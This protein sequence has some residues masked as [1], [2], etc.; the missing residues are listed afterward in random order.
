MPPAQRQI[1]QQRDV[2]IANARY[3]WARLALGSGQTELA[4]KAFR[5]ALELRRKA[6]GKDHPDVAKVV[7]T[8]AGICQ[9]QGRFIE[10]EQLCREGVE[11]RRRILPPGTWT[12]GNAKS[13]LGENLM[14]QRKF[15]E[16]ERLL[17]EANEDFDAHPPPATEAKMVGF[18]LQRLVW[19]YEQ[20]GKP[21]QAAAW[22]AK[23]PPGAEPLNTRIF[24][25]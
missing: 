15:S 14:G 12:T 6:F 5:E 23:V 10:A 9:K 7:L 22:R 20:W 19:L 25:P 21:E 11:I 3:E 16:A 18:N 1:R 4:E 17:L 13:L 8:L 2:D 24:A